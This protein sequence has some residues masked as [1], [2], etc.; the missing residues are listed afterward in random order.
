M[1]LIMRRSLKSN[2]WD[3]INLGTPEQ[4]THDNMVNRW[5]TERNTWLH[6]DSQPAAGEDDVFG[7]V[8]KSPIPD[9]NTSAHQLVKRTMKQLSGPY[10]AF[11]EYHPLED[12]VTLYHEIWNESSSDDE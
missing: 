10:G 6:L 3:E 2:R 5:V 12:T 11:N 8:T 1:Q 4:Y 7:G 9:R